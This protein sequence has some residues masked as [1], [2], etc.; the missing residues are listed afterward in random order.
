MRDDLISVY[1]D[2]E[3]TVMDLRKLGVDDNRGVMEALR[4]A[5]CYLDDMITEESMDGEE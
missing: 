3:D 2:I 1:N 4:D 5:L